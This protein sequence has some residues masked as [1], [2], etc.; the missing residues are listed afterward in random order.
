MYQ[1]ELKRVE[2]KISKLFRAGCFTNKKI[3]LF[4][5]SDNSRQIITMLRI[6]GVEPIAIIDNDISKQGSYCARKPVISFEDVDELK[7]DDNLFIIYSAFWPEMIGQFFNA[8]VTKN[9]ILLLCKKRNSLLSHI[10]EA[11]VGRHEYKRICQKYGTKDIFLCPYTGTG[12]IY[13]IGTFWQEYCKINNIKNY[14]FVVISGA[15]KNVA[16]LC[17]IRNVE[18]LKKQRLS[19]YIISAHMLWP[20]EVKLKILNDC[21][22]QIHTNQIEWF[23]GYKGLEFTQLFKKYV[24]N[25]SETSKPKHP[26]L[27]SADDEIKHLM[28]KNDLIEGNTIVL[29]PYSNTLYDLPDEFWVKLSEILLQRGFCV[30]TN[31]SGKAEP[32][33]KGSK[34]VFFPLTIAPQFI[35]K[36]GYFIG[37]RSGFCDI[38]SGSKAK[39][40][41]LYDEKNRFYMGSA[42]EYFNLKDMELCDDA[43][44]IKFSNDDWDKNLELILDS[45]GEK[46]E[47]RT[48]DNVE[49]RR[50]NYF[51]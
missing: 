9:N 51:L 45:V 43:I 42:Y 33:V 10:A 37:V 35:E 3:Y 6:H 31:S 1:E 26:V 29:S 15:C 18:L 25:L 32:A 16:K 14:A 19:R 4:G 36:A 46:H 24:F 20:D 22:A 11:Y 23:R 41:I 40:I 30:C 12:D 2:K 21:W 39:K 38:I 44:E 47:S 50:D 27:K 49:I 8:G 28:K 48:I 13:L 17:E 34:G 5:V 7:A